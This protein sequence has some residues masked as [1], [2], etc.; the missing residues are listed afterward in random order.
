MQPAVDS[1][2]TAREVELSPI[3]VDVLTDF[4]DH[5]KYVRRGSAH[6]VR[7]YSGDARKLARFCQERG[8][9]DPRQ[10]TLGVLRSWLADIRSKGASSAT[11]ARSAA[12]ARAF[13]GVLVRNQILDSDPGQRL[14]ASAVP[15]KL[16]TVLRTDQINAV[17]DVAGEET[18]REPAPEHFRDKALLELLYASGIRISELCGLD[19]ADI[20]HERQTIRV[21]GKGNKQRTVPV[22]APAMGSINEWLTHGRPKLATAESDGALFLGSRGKRLDQRVARKVVTVA[23]QRV[24]G[25]PTVAPHGL[26]HTAATHVLEGGADLRTVQELLGHATLGTTQI[27]THVTL[28]RLRSVYEQAHPRA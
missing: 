26:R 4:E 15:R 28:E 21:L 3:W 27:Y 23:T 24:S 1:E 22:G 11:I 13:T 10:L 25:V 19:L 6:T 20:D 18:A 7:A 2:T 5:L 17:L 9:A 8:L 12:S 14:V 16:P